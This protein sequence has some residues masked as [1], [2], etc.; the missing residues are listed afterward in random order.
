MIHIKTAY[1]DDDAVI[2]KGKYGDGST[3]LVLDDAVTGERLAKITVCMQDYDLKPTNERHVFVKDYAENEGML[4]A[5]QAAGI[6]SEE[7][8][9]HNAGWAQSGVHEVRVLD[10]DAIENL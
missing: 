1:I 3:A 2:R 9:T 6:V 7:L 4:K 8:V 5:L 10:F